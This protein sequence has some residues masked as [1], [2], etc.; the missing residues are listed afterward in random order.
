MATGNDIPYDGLTRVKS[1]KELERNSRKEADFFERSVDHL[2]SALRV[3]QTDKS[4]KE[5]I[6]QL[7]KEIKEAENQFQK[8][9]AE[10]ILAVKQKQQSG[11]TEEELLAFFKEK[12]KE[13]TETTTDFQ[14]KIKKIGTSINEKAKES[15]VIGLKES[16]ILY[17]QLSLAERNTK[18]L[19]STASERNSPANRSLERH[20][21]GS[22][23]EDEDWGLDSAFRSQ[24]KTAEEIK[25]ILEKSLKTAIKE[26]KE[27]RREAELQRLIEQDHWREDRDREKAREK[28]DKKLRRKRKFQDKIADKK[29]SLVAGLLSPFKKLTDPLFEL[30]TDEGL[31]TEEFFQ[32]RF[33]KKHEDKRAAEDHEIE[34]RRG[35]EDEDRRLER[36]LESKKNELIVDAQRQLES[37]AG[38][39]LALL[40]HFGSQ[41]NNQEPP[42][43]EGAA[44]NPPGSPPEETGEREPP[45]SE[46]D[47]VSP[48]S[49]EN[50]LDSASEEALRREPPVSEVGSVSSPSLEGENNEET[51][52]RLTS[53]EYNPLLEKIAPNKSALLAKGGVFGAAAVYLGRLLGDQL[54]DMTEGQDK[55]KDEDGLLDNAN[56]LLDAKEHLDEL[57]K[58]GG[59][60][61]KLLPTL[62]SVA[63]VS[64]VAA[65]P[66]AMLAGGAAL[67]KR[68]S[69]DADKYAKE[70]NLGRAAETAWLGDRA[71]LTE[72]NANSELGRATGK[73]TLL[74]GGAAGVG[75]LTLG[76]GA[77]AGMAAGGAAAAGGAG[78]LGTGLAAAGAAAAAV[79]PPVLIGAAIAA[80]VTVIAK[81]TQEAFELGW[82]KNQASIQKELNSVIFDEDATV[83]EKIKANAEST[84]KG[85]T[86][87]LAGGIREAG[88]VLDAETMIQNKRQIKFLREQADAGNKDYARLL[89]MMQSEQFKAMDESGQKMLMQSEGLYDDYKKMQ[90]ETQ[91]SFG[92]HLLTAGRTVG[93]FFTGLVDTTV[94]G[95][96]GKETAQ[97]EARTLKGMEMTENMSEEDIAR[98]KQSQEYQDTMANGGDTK[99][100]MEAAYLKE[101]KD[102][103]IA[104]G[105]LTK[106]GMAVQTGGGVQGALA[107]YAA[108]GLPGAIV[109]GIAGDK[110][111]KYFGLGDMGLAYKERKTGT[112]ELDNEYRQTFEYSKRKA[113][114][115]DKGKTAEEADLAVIAEQ[116][117]LYHDALTLRLK[118]SEDYK[119]AFEEE[120][121]LSGDI[122]KA[123]TEGLKAANKNKKNV[124]AT[125]KL[126]KAKFATLWKTAK[127]FGGGL[128][129]AGKEGLAWLGDKAAAVGNFLVGGDQEADASINDGI[130]LKSGKVVELSPDDNVYATKNEP[131]VVRDQEAQAAM[132]SVPKTPAEFTDKNIVAMLQAIL[133]RLD[134]IDVKPQ[135]VTSG[136][137]INFDGLK[138][139]GAL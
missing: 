120:L 76:G 55:E 7:R 40:P 138:M 8:E 99:S 45:V 35:Q 77:A 69:E 113:E 50:D 78:L 102:L 135:V 20:S 23:D 104:R 89:D 62:A 74:A 75:A 17:D 126:L 26:N 125:N 112:D 56:G 2:D 119:K 30:F 122:K 109:G 5:E 91:K 87:S 83:W 88:S 66:L 136:G 98:L 129:D 92:E 14:N 73:T 97:W 22:D 70:G 34:K 80:G 105:E 24:P 63:G 29:G 95:I 38:G 60:L 10:L 118:Q 103:A 130:V 28:E 21:D 137:D 9:R 111:G 31:N 41:L 132:P 127:D 93:G 54:D 16:R 53:A 110:L 43:V 32:A 18:L 3:L 115:M 90:Q 13:Y 71:R 116:N 133:A 65:I 86:G 101:Q 123:E 108:G 134:K 128:L 11:A 124:L 64:A 19:E 96:R 44:D 84:W 4:K 114:L 72:E 139:A 61:A 81:G 106:D 57:I 58:P 51:Q 49:V 59:V 46:V 36:E 52:E 42:P 79:L 68:D 94:E 12:S 100:A 47:R 107:G 117:Q 39:E 85:F 1:V 37:I 33:R 25:E 131:R 82:D 121:K 27:R 67:Q 15:N 6:A 48:P